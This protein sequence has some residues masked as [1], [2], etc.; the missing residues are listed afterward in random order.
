MITSADSVENAPSGKY[1]LPRSYDVLPDRSIKQPSGL[2]VWLLQALLN[3][4]SEKE[5]LAG[6]G[7]FDDGIGC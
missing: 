1:S 2:S 5:Y 7:V 3:G 4:T 6:H